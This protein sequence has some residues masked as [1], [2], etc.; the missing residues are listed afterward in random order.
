MPEAR[1]PEPNLEDCGRGPASWTKLCG[2]RM[3]LPAG[4]KS[5]IATVANGFYQ[6]K[7]LPWRWCACERRTLVCGRL[8]RQGLSPAGVHPG[9]I[10]PRRWPAWRASRP[11]R[12]PANRPACRSPGEMR[13]RQHAS[14][15]LVPACP[16]TG[17]GARRGGGRT[18]PVRAVPAARRM[19][20]S[21][22]AAVGHGWPARHLGRACR[23]GACRVAPR[24]A[25]WRAGERAAA[26][27]SSLRCGPRQ[28]G[29]AAASPAAGVPA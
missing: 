26:V 1:R 29:E 3:K 4:L 19:L 20:R 11:Q 5:R 7:Q 28:A 18:R 21:L 24:V 12:P 13:Q 17:A 9:N 23:G 6:W 15:R 25:G 16:G 8:L 22:D 14:G 10:P 27:R 2:D